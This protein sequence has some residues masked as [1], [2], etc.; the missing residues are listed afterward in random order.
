MADNLRFDGQVAIVTG[1]GGGLGRAYALLLASRGAKVVVNDLGGSVDGKGADARAADKVV[2][3]IRAAGGTAEPN[4]DSVEN[5][6]KI[7][8]TAVDKFGRVDIVVN[9]AGILRDRSFLKMTDQDWDLIYKVHLLGTYKVTKAAWPI[10]RQQKY[11]RIINVSSASGLYGNEGQGNYAAMKMGVVGLSTT[12]AKEGARHNVKVNVIAPIAGSRMTASIMPPDLVEA[13]KPDYV[14]PV[15][16]YLAHE[17]VPDSGAVFELGAGWVSRLRWQRSQ[18]SFFQLAS[19][20]PEAVAD[21]FDEI[22]D[23]DDRPVSYPT[24]NNDAFGEIMSNLENQ[25]TPPAGAAAAG[26]G[27]AA[28]APAPGSHLKSAPLFELMEKALKAEGAALSK[29][30]NGSYRFNVDDGTWVL[31]LKGVN[32]T[33]RAGDKDSPVDCTVTVSDNDFVLIVTGKLNSQ[34]AFMKGRL[35][36]KGNMGLAMKLEPIMKLARKKANL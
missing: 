11:G 32:P 19:F 31:D 9:N 4:Y 8:Q 34:Q 23:F 28:A 7:V 18:G 24:S 27:G 3:E 6:D 25:K 20:T 26:G 22:S 1:A 10:M 12:L 29:K 13:L 36:I 14:A 5:G 35:K 16:A 30:I 21:K 15:V 33:L 2:Q 17:S